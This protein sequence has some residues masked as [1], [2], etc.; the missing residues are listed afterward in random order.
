MKEKFFYLYLSI[1]FLGV[2]ITV[3]NAEIQTYTGIGEYIMSNQETPEAATNNA[4]IYAERSACEQAGIFIS[5]H[6]EMKNNNLDKD[7]IETFTAGILKILKTN[8]EVI[9]LTGEA[10]G[11][12]KYRVSVTANIDTDTLNNSINR[13]M[14]KSVENR[15]EETALNS[16]FKKI[17]DEQR[18][19][20]AKLEKDL[21]NAKNSKDIEKVKSELKNLTD[22]AV[23]YGKVS[24]ATGVSKSDKIRI[25]TEAIEMNPIGAEAYFWRAL[26]FNGK[27]R[28]DDLN[29]AIA[30]DPSYSEAYYF[31]A[32]A[33]GMLNDDESAIEDYTKVIELNSSK[34]FDAYNGRAHCYHELQEYHKA[35]EDYTYL[36]KM[37]PQ[38]NLN[39]ANRALCYYN[40]ADYV[41]AI[42]DYTK[43]FSMVNPNNIKNPKLRLYYK[44][45][46]ECYQA[47]GETEKAASDFA[48]A[49]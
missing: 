4:K 5:S 40:V 8:V 1:I 30:I 47:L 48:M 17:I 18:N 15:S 6:S 37:K 26:Q 13:W 2:F 42:E 46:G 12:I 35:I 44:F 22:L 31:R 49:E 21:K 7:E 38:N 39:Y 28:I 24:Q 27:Q 11:W 23:Y 20:I 10:A 3:A 36:I 25:L 41:H 29:R 43:Y 32:M 16:N 45:R 14:N 9:P 33:Y 34:K 19:K